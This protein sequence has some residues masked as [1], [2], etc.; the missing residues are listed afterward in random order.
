MLISCYVNKIKM[1]VSK[2]VFCFMLKT[3]V[4]EKLKNSKNCL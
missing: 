2:K 1:L 4:I 3:N